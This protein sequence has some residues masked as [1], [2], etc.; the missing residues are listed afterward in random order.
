[1]PQFNGIGGATTGATATINGRLCTQ[2][3]IPSDPVTGVWLSGNDI[4]RADFKTGAKWE[5]T[6]NVAVNPGYFSNAGWGC[7][8]Q[9]CNKMVD[10]VI[11]L[12]ESGSIVASDFGRMKTFAQ[13]FANLY[14]FG[15]QQ[16]GMGLVMFSTTARVAVG[17]TFI[18][19]SF[20]NGVSA[21][22]QARQETCITCGGQAAY[23]LLLSGGRGVTRVIVVLT[24]GVNNIGTTTQLTQT[25]NNIKNSGTYVFSIGVGT[26]VDQAQIQGLASSGLAGVQTSFP[27]V[28]SFSA[29]SGILD[30]LV[31]ATCVNLQ[32]N[33]CGPTCRGFCSWCN[34]CVPLCL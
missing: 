26:G 5:F 32:G 1:M 2:Y 25:F 18:K 19:A 13:Q 31:Q 10:F 23:N 12:D 20:I 3:T 22:G 17:I 9:Q 16:T 11:V 28:P 8:A 4:C 33:P 7:P 15:V 34:L 24:D 30:Q 14:T 27:N 6:N 29:L 21:V